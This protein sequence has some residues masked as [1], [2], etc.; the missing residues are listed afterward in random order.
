MPTQKKTIDALLTPFTTT[1]PAIAKVFSTVQT[2]LG[3][4]VLE[5]VIEAV[6]F[7]M[8]NSNF[9]EASL[10]QELAIRG[11]PVGVGTIC[12]DGF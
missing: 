2:L 1:V 11:E 10:H 12:G 3:V 5:L 4:T 9:L 8:E 7:V 6:L